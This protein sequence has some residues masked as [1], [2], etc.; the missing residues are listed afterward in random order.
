MPDGLELNECM[1]KDLPPHPEILFSIFEAINT[2]TTENQGSITQFCFHIEHR[3]N[4]VNTNSVKQSLVQPDAPHRSTEWD[5]SPAAPPPP[6][7]L[8]G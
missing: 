2:Q 6:A 4:W 1:Q 8:Q 5:H 7:L 3:A